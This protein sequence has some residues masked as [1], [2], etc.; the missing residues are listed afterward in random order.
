MSN[1][2]IQKTAE[3]VNVVLEVLK[4]D[5]VN[6]VAT[7]RA[8]ISHNG[9]EW[10]RDYLLRLNEYYSFEKMKSSLQADI[11]RDLISANNIAELRAANNFELDITL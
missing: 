6:M 7:A 10:T 3:K 2:A 5:R 8:T 9:D 4:I 11:R 1:K